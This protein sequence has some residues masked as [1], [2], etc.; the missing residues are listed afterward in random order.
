MDSWLGPLLLAAMFF[1]WLLG[2]ADRRQATASAPQ[3]PPVPTDTERGDDAAAVAIA[4][5]AAAAAPATPR[6]RLLTAAAQLRNVFEAVAHPSDLA[7]ITTFQGCAE[8]LAGPEFRI[9]ELFGYLV[10]DSSVLACAA[11]GALGHRPEFVGRERELV[12]RL[13]GISIYARWF[14]LPTIARSTDPTAAFDVML[15]GD[16]SWGSAMGMDLLRS[17]VR[18]RLDA[19]NVVAPAQRER[20][21]RCDA[22]HREWLADLL[23]PIDTPAARAVLEQLG[24]RGS[25]D[26][27]LREAAPF[28]RVLDRAALGP[29]PLPVPAQD[30]ALR[31]LQQ[32]LAREGSRSLLLVGEPGVG[33]STVALRFAAQLAEAGWTVF[34]ASAAQLLAGQSYVGQLEQRVQDLVRAVGHRRDVLWLVP[35]FAEFVGAGRTMHTRT[36]ALDLLLPHVA[37]G[38]LRILAP[39][40]PTAWEL[41]LREQ[42]ALRNATATVRLAECPADEA[43]AAGRAWVARE[44]GAAPPLADDRL[45]AELFQRTRQLVAGEAQPGGLLRLLGLLREHLAAAGGPRPAT[46][47]DVIAVLSRS[48]GLPAAVLDDRAGLDLNSLR[49]AFTNRVK[50]QP[51]AVDCL[52]ERIAMLTAG[53][54]DPRRPI[55]VF[56]FTGPTGTGKT[57]LCRALAEYLFGSEDR[58]LRLDMSEF[59]HPESI[60]RLLGDADAVH[61]RLALVHQIREQP[62]TVLL[63]DEIEKAHPMVFDLF[64]QVFDEG[65]LT[66]RRGRTADFR[67]AFVI[68][69]SNLGVRNLEGAGLGFG[70]RAPDLQR[71]LEEVFRREFLNRIDRVVVFR[72]LEQAT[73]REVLHKELD[74][75]LQ[76]R[77]LRQRPWA[78]EWDESALQFL[79]QQGY[80]PSLGARPLRRAIERHVLAPLAA[81]IVSERTPAGDQF[82]FVR[83][84]GR[85]VQVEFVDPDAAP[86]APPLPPA[87]VAASLRALA[88]EASGREGEVAA[89]QRELTGLG[90]IVAGSGW[91]VRKAAAY[92]AMGEPDFWTS[93]RRHEVL[94]CAELI[95]RLEEAVAVAGAKAAEF[96]GRGRDVA[97]EPLR[98]LASRTLLL[99]LAVGALE[100]GEAQD[101]YLALAPVHDPH[102]DEARA[103]AFARELVSMYRAWAERRGMEWRLLGDGGAVVAAVGGF[104]AWSVLQGE[105]GLH[106]LDVGD[107]ATRP[108]RVRVAVAPQPAAPAPANGELAQAKESLRPAQAAVPQVVRRYRRE[109]SPEIR[110]RLRGWRTGRWDRV[111]GG[112]F[113]V[114]E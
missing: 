58:M 45:L 55:G 110:D 39:L 37:S 29:E 12:P 95:S 74:L 5:P 44:R 41:L 7:A 33:K 27:A 91:G 87:P 82:L 80:S 23:E 98:R 96:A 65:R 49:R 92:A 54:C 46:L 101:A 24:K 32:A 13:D 62:F 68:A 78:V 61:G 90:E 111:L 6:A 71:A 25:G 85:G 99:Q 72:A 73:L 8:L 60:G 20:L 75:V 79:L 53:L 48:T 88:R 84:D 59:Q 77:G 36:G 9:D 69:T 19:G 18:E 51:E 40:V 100:R 2:R 38:E 63:L 109:P 47:D 66:D 81:A 43:L 89:L 102:G 17:F 104:A 57:E 1:G 28:V 16:R 3:R 42:P 10:G 83:S 52:V 76:R 31:E 14:L 105:A 56:L 67:H 86:P 106:V 70:E 64:L 30:Q 108:I 34:T 97:A 4:E 107:E 93:P 22:E 21:A 94:G 50:G 11:A 35:D 114:L 113:D 26:A 112:E 15:L 103:V